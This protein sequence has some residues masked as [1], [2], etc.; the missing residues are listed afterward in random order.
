[1]TE[2]LT[3][4]VAVITGAASGIGEATATRFVEEGARVVVADIQVESGMAVAD[5]LGAAARFIECDV[6]IE[7]QVADAVDLAIATWG[8]LDCMFNNAGVIGAV[9]PLVDTTEEAWNR[10]IGILLNSVF[11]GIKHA[12]RVMTPARSGVILSTSS[13]AGLVAGLGPHAYTVAK[14]GILALTRSAAIE[15]GPHGI[16]VNAIAPGTIPTAM[17]ALAI[18]GDAAAVEAATEHARATNVLGIA[19]APIDV[20]NA[21]LFLA[22]DEARFITGHTLVVDAGRS[23]EGGSDRFKGVDTAM[24]E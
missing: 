7:G 8:R 13:V 19:S 2:R 10:T 18:T 17:T 12:A 9:G 24:L 20:A 11:F 4:K 22:S 23:I 3:G 16:R 5:R 1:M 6:T 14:T 15:L 21:A